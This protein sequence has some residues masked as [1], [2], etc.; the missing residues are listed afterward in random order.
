A[1]WAGPA[2]R[3]E[4]WR[5]SLRDLAAALLTPEQLRAVL[6][7]DWEQAGSGLKA[8]LY[9]ELVARGVRPW[10]A[11]A[12]LNQDWNAAQELGIVRLTELLGQYLGVSPELVHAVIDRD[13]AA[14]RDQAQVEVLE[15]LLQARLFDTPQA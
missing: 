10:E 9:Q 4:G 12:L 6:N 3:A 5:E 11:D 7:G 13:W 14:A 15:R 2:T 1:A 8:A